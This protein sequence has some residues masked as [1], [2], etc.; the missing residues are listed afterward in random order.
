LWRGAIAKGNNTTFLSQ[1]TY[2]YLSF[3]TDLLRV[4]HGTIEMVADKVHCTTGRPGENQVHA[5]HG[6]SKR[7]ALSCQERLCIQRYRTWTYGVTIREASLGDPNCAWLCR[8]E[9]LGGK[10]DPTAK[11]PEHPS[12]LHAL[13]DTRTEDV[14][15]QHGLRL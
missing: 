5:S 12:I 10:F 9:A 4:P 15:L 13:P 1:H 7:A 3:R 14:R 11:V 6:L 8:P 2:R